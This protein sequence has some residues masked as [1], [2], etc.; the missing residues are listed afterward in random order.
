MDITTSETNN[1]VRIVTLN[2]P[3]ALN[4]FNQDLFDALCEEFLDASQ[5]QNV[6]VLVLTGAGRA[7]SAGA[8]LKARAAGEHAK[9]KHG[10]EGMLEAII[11]F[12]KPLIVAA[13]GLGVGIGCTLLGLGDMTFV[14][15]SSRFRAPFSALGI[16]AEGSSTYTFSRLVGHQKASWILLSSEWISAD[17]CVSSGL[18]LSVYPDE[19]FIE[20][21]MAHANT[22]AKLPLASLIQT[23]KL[24]MAP[25]REAMLMAV[26]EENRA[27]D[28][29]RGGPA[30]Q[31]A[32]NAFLEK[33]DPDFANL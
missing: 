23:K 32:M 28:T 22:L 16:T 27:L 7:F 21:V 2:R 18:A 12:P 15:Q 3:K 19:T 10:L 6:K 25:H 24:M 9:P 26:R 13:N 14:S 30:N 29:L 5:D 8:D 33:R 4:A 1:A 17:E 20:E 11:N 31:E